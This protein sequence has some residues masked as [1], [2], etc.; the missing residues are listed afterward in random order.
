[1]SELPLP[2]KL[3]GYKMNTIDFEKDDDTNFHM[4][5]IT[6]T[7][8]LRATNYSIPNCDKHKAK[9]NG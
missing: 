5:F 1:M 8:N 4:D 3:P 9:G 7:A 2:S 6:A